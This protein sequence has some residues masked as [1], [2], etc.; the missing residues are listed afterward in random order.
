MICKQYWYFINATTI[1]NNSCDN[2]PASA[3]TATATTNNSNN[4]NNNNVIIEIIITIKMKNGC[5]L[6]RKIKST[7]YERVSLTNFNSTL[8]Y[9]NLNY[10]P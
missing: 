10:F 2:T 3:V 7:Y 1:D 4:Y 5:A 9:F 6:K 8:E